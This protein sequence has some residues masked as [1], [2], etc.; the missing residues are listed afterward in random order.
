M[1]ILSLFDG[2]SCGYEALKR[3]NIPITNYY[4][5]EIDKYAIQCSTD[6]HQDIIQIGDVR[7][8]SFKDG[9]LI[10]NNCSY[11]VGKIDL[12]IGGSPCQNFSGLR[13]LSC[14]EIDGLNG[15]LS[16]LFY[17]FVR[18]LNEINPKYFLLEN[19]VIHNEVQLRE[20]NSLLGCC[21]VI[22]NSNLVSY[23]NR[24]RSYWTNITTSSIVDRNKSF[25][26]YK[27]TNE[28]YCNNFIVSKTPYHMRLWYDGKWK[29]VT[30]AI[31]IECLTC[32]QDRFINSG[33]VEYNGF[34]RFLTTHELE[35]AQTL[36]IGYTRV[37]S[38]CQAE[39]A[40]GNCWTVDI[41]AE[42]FKN[43]IR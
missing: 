3:S 22:Y 29:N 25:Q 9:K 8:I 30:N 1:N 27:D 16:Y 10:A 43:I 33:V 14:K 18:L 11:D 37:L 5:S 38:K 15:N 2:I 39:K 42:I 12:V 40:L 24:K 19:V 4:S 20:I 41:I 17:E 35:Q 13:A 21:P 6:N 23:Q 34:C 26:D 7:N 36:P 31:K 32:K 28:S